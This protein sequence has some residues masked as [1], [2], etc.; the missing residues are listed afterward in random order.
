MIKNHVAVFSVVGLLIGV[1]TA[2]WITPLIV[3]PAQEIKGTKDSPVEIPDA[4][5]S[6]FTG[7]AL[8]IDGVFSAEL[9]NGSEWNLTD[10]DVSLTLTKKSE[11][12]RFRME[13]KERR[14]EWQS[15]AKIPNVSTTKITLSAYA[16]G[17]FQAPV[18]RF[19]ADV[20]SKDEYTWTLVSARGF[21]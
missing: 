18:G 4:A 13:I 14:P 19:M 1:G 3:K 17:E 10:V 21:K 16:A 12:R 8:C 2:M 20:S 7:S 15:G 6:K 11:T 9:Y 5:L